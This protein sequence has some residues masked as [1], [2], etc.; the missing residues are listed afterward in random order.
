MNAVALF[1]GLLFVGAFGFL[2]GMRFRDMLLRH[3]R[4]ERD[5]H[6]RHAEEW[7]KFAIRV[8]DT[9]NEACGI[10]YARDATVIPIGMAR[11]GPRSDKPS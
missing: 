8:S 5:M 9:L 6:K 11:R 4:E 3:A 1:L 10:S 7:R 2:S